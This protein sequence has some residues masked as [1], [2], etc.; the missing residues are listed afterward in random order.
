MN[1]NP[2]E[3]YWLL[4]EQQRERGNSELAECFFQKALEAAKTKDLTGQKM[5]DSK[6]NSAHRANP[7]LHPENLSSGK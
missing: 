1:F 6:A 3:F 7:N 5:V 2:F 4:A